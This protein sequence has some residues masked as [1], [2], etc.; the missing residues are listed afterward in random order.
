MKKLFRLAALATMASLVATISVT[1]SCSD[2]DDDENN[3]PVVVDTTKNDTVVPPEQKDTVPVANQEEVFEL[4]VGGSKSKAHSFISIQD[5]RTYSVAE[6]T[7]RKGAGVEIVFDGS[8]LFSASG[9]AN[10]VVRQNGCAAVLIMESD[11]VFKFVTSGGE[12][13]KGY[14]GKIE[15]IEGEMK[16]ETSTIKIRITRK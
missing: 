4:E 15:V 10:E 16:D 11:K 2:D 12:N 6:V 3:N 9:S 5:K 14:S 8:K 7:M 13:G 1:T